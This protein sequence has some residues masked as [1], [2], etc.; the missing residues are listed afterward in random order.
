LS[1]H[2]FLNAVDTVAEAVESRRNCTGFLLWEPVPMF[3]N[4]SWQ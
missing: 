2:G 4:R 1:L 3:G